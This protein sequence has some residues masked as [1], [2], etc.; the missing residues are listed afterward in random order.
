MKQAS[1]ISRHASVAPLFA[2][3]M[4]ALLGSDSASAAEPTSSDWEW[5]EGPRPHWVLPRYPDIKDGSGSLTVKQPERKTGQRK[6]RPHNASFAVPVEATDV[7]VQFTLRLGDAETVGVRWEQGLDR[8]LVRLI[9]TAESIRLET[10]EPERP[11]SDR[12]RIQVL[13]T[14]PIQLDSN[15]D[16]EVSLSVTESQ[17]TARVGETRLTGKHPTFARPKTAVVWAVQSGPATLSNFQLRLDGQLGSQ[18][19]VSGPLLKKSLSKTNPAKRENS[20]KDD[21]AAI[22]RKLYVDT[23]R[24]ILKRACLGCHSHAS[25]EANGGLM[26]DSYAAIRTGGE[27]GSA[28]VPHD[29]DESWLLAAVRYN[30]EFY[31]MPPDGRLPQSDIDAI[32]RWIETGAVGDVDWTA[33]PTT[34]GEASQPIEPPLWSL[35]SIDDPPVPNV[36]NEKWPKSDLDRFV[37]HRLE[38]ADLQPAADAEPAVLLRR[39]AFVLTGLPPNPDEIAAFNTAHQRDPD[40]AVADAIDQRLG[41]QA[42]GERWGRHWLDLA[43]YADVAGGTRPAPMAESWR[44]RNYVIDSWASG[45][46]FDDFVREQLA[47]DLL[48]TSNARDRAENLV[49]TGFLALGH[50]DANEKDIARVRM[51]RIDEQLDTIGKSM[52]GLTLGCA[53]CHDHKFDPIPTRD[54]YAL[55]GILGSTKTHTTQPRQGAKSI[56]ETLPTDLPPN[57]P[58]WL[59]ARETVHR[60]AKQIKKS[61]SKET[62]PPRTLAVRD[63]PQSTD[64]PVHLR[65]DVDRTGDVVP[66]G[67]L[68]AVGSPSA[69]IPTTQSGRRELADWILADDNPLA[70]RVLV[71]RIWR[72]VFGQGLVRTADNFGR[73]GE[74]PSHPA[75]L[76][77]LANRLRTPTNRGGL[78]WSTS[79]LIREL[80]M[81]RTFRQ[82]SVSTQQTDSTAT[83]AHHPREVDP[84]NRLLWRAN[85]RRLDA[86]ALHDTLFAVA[87]TLDRSPAEFTV[88]QGFV[89]SNTA[90]TSNVPIP[91]PT[92]RKR[93]V[94][95]PIFR[96]DVPVDL[97]LLA[98][99]DFAGP[100]ATQG[101][102]DASTVPA[103]ALLLMNSPMVLDTARALNKRLTR[104]AADGADEPEMIR[105]LYLRTIC[106]E[107][108]DR[109]RAD[110]S[111][112]LDS[113]S[114]ALAEANAAKQPRNVA[115]N[116][117]CH[118]LLLSNAFL[119]ID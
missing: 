43:R 8:H 82:A 53:R 27:S 96:K 1:S 110:C 28:A 116:R 101:V 57:A 13:D 71:N 93:A 99:F 61:T 90:N 75:L 62:G 100:M 42:F 26:L 22:S 112:F 94:Y 65:G 60:S 19:S 86:E 33:K 20:K 106:R 102:R 54:Y 16:Y 98:T 108:N 88:P 35:Q 38:A 80:L 91:K 115:W 113:F 66:R 114:T 59:T 73:M 45:K 95:W 47:G 7:S 34:T 52:L 10:V 69:S 79:A 6:R 32:K 23:V 84:E 31:D 12:R 36:Q 49:A 117:L 68:S 89:V 18:Q 83:A 72:H 87:G 24:P 15:T 97:D 29:V 74:P 76:D 39:I 111:A 109:E 55:A 44:Y 81:S 48:P 118:T 5:T 103:Q 85:R 104:L 40:A 4:L 9:I 46:P 11:R 78:G 51:D 30:G 67:F 105:Q 63:E 21:T 41:T 2:A 56:F 17:A 14:T 107:P 119:V 50:Y 77:H 3:L 70:A 58:T 25:G 64:E 37:L 92:L